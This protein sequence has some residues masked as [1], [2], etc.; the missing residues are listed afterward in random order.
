MKQPQFD[1]PIDGFPGF[2]ADAAS[3]DTIYDVRLEVRDARSLRT[4][5]VEMARIASSNKNKNAVLILEEPEIS[6][7]RLLNEWEGVISVIRPELLTQLSMVFRKAG[8]WDGF[9][10][11]PKAEDT[12]I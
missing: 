3:D 4:A 5:L 12:Q 2:R 11:P 6:I 1:V 8:Q 9:P 7:V 10:A